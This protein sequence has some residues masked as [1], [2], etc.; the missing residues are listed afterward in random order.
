MPSPMHDPGEADV[1]HR[2]IETSVQHPDLTREVPFDKLAE[3]MHCCIGIETGGVR[4]VA[5][6]TG[7]LTNGA[8]FKLLHV[9]N[10][11]IQEE[12]TEARIGTKTMG[13]SLEIRPG[14]N[15][16]KG[17]MV[18][19]DGSPP[20]T[21]IEFGEPSDPAFLNAFIEVSSKFDRTVR[22]ED[23]PNKEMNEERPNSSLKEASPGPD[24]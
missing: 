21:H 15:L 17:K 7:S 10:L 8:T 18:T 6:Q 11:I 24:T 22:T 1:E 23:G 19:I 5:S 14:L 13:I 4:E 16:G 2:G 3:T 9:D 12:D 20:Q